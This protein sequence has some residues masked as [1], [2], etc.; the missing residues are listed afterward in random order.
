MTTPATRRT[1]D[2]IDG[3]TSQRPPGLQVVATREE[4]VELALQTL[5]E[6]MEQHTQLGLYLVAPETLWKLEGEQRNRKGEL[7][8]GLM[9]HQVK[10]TRDSFATAAVVGQRTANE[11]YRMVMAS[12]G[13]RKEFMGDAMTGEWRPCA[14]AFKGREVPARALTDNPDYDANYDR[15]SI[16]HADES[17]K[18]QRN[19]RQ[20]VMQERVDIVLVWL[21]IT[22]APPYDRLRQELNRGDNPQANF[23]ASRQ[24]AN[25]P[26][27]VQAEIR[28]AEQFHRRFML[29]QYPDGIPAER[30]GAMQAAERY[31]AKDLD[32]PAPR[33]RA[34]RKLAP[35]SNG[36]A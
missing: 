11:W 32:L 27:A 7:Q 17:I 5:A 25:A 8:A 12:T 21:E 9:R 14:M 22:G 20:V 16:K 36:S 26:Y 33:K 34:P 1:L 19:I 4:M 24:F 6:P 31:V 15:A 28:E 3:F 2:L 29:S 30:Q 35:E 13:A 10:V 18:L 23:Y